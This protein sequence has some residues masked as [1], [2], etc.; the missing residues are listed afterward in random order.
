[1][2][3]LTIEDGATGAGVDAGETPAFAV[4]LE[5]FEGRFDLLL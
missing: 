4:R 2:T 5:N 3:G 1:M